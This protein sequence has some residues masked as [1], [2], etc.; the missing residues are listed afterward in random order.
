MARTTKAAEN[1]ETFVT[2]SPTFHVKASRHIFKAGRARPL[3]VQRKLQTNIHNFLNKFV[4]LK[5]VLPCNKEEKSK[6]ELMVQNKR[7]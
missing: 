7:H 6:L 1:E 5:I 4:G 2:A 3:C